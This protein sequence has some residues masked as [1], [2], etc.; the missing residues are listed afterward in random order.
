MYFLKYCNL[1]AHWPSSALQTPPHRQSQEGPFLFTLPVI[2]R[3]KTSVNIRP[4]PS[5][6]FGISSGVHP[7]HVPFHL[8]PGD[9]E[10]TQ[11]AIVV[12]LGLG[13]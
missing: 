4:T 12:G 6:R 1:Y 9:V 8:R 3:L 7:A 11:C 5:C 10:I 13:E 2:I